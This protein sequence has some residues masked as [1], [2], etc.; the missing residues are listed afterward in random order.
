MTLIGYARLIRLPNLIMIA[1]TAYLA[2]YYLI[3][4]AFETEFN[5]TGVYPEHLGRLSFSLLV[6]FTICVA[7]GG[8][9]INDVY[10]VIP[11]N[12]NRPGENPVG[13]GINRKQAIHAAVALS[14]LGAIGGMLLAL[15]IG[16]P[17]MGF[18]HAFCAISLW[19]YSAE[20]KMRFLTG[21]LITAALTFLVVI[22]PGLYEPEY[23][24]NIIYLAVYAAFAFATTFIREIIKDIEDIEGD[25]AYQCETIPIRIGVSRTKI[26]VSTLVVGMLA[27]LITVLY[28]SFN[29][30][31]V[32]GW[33]N[34]AII[35]GIPLLAVLYLLF[36]AEEK[37][38]YTFI[39]GFVKL[40]MLIGILSMLPFWYF[41]LK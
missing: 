24:R 19:R 11:D 29:N 5:I 17:I 41:F 33:W 23:Y 28:I 21:N 10:D 20:F 39:S 37:K 4:P 27:G 22:L 25:R 40:Y 38:D 7:A 3:L 15:K 35:S 31:T 30:N 36:H 34:L 6:F 1:L 18:I 2:R 8:Y 9:I 32:I 26:L 14:V 16:K 12:I 13:H